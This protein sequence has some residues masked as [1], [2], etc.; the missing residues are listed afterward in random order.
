[1]V[2]VYWLATSDGTMKRPCSF[3]TALYTVF[4][5]SWVTLMAA[6]GIT[7]EL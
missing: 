6:F 1:M 7:A 4:V 5:E 2:I 3:D